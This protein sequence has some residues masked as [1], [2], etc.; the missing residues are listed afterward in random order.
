MTKNMT[1]LTAALAVGVGIHLALTL[2]LLLRYLEGRERQIGWW[3]VAYAFFATHVVAETL[4]T[5]FPEPSLIAFRHALFLAASWAMVQSFRQDPRVTIAALAGMLASVVLASQSWLAAAVIASVLGGGGFMASALLLYRQ[6]HGVHPVSIK[7]LFWGL[8]LTGLQALAYP[9]LRPHPVYAGVGAAFSGAF[10]LIFSVGIV[11][12][13]LQRSRDLATMSSIAE[14]LN[15][16]LDVPSALGRALDQ[17]VELMRLSSGWVFLRQNGDFTVAATKNLPLELAASGMA[18]MQG[19]CRCLQML[20]DGQLSEAVNVVDC[21]RLEQAGWDHPR[22]VT[23]PLRSAGGVI[24]V[25]NLVLPRRRALSIRELATLS[26]IGDQIG[27][28]AERARLYDEVRAKEVLRGELLQKLISA[29]E[30]ERRR[31]ARELHDEA[32]QAL[33]AL[34][35]NLEVAER[36]AAPDEQPRLGRLRE[37][38]E[39]TLGELRKMIYDLRPTILDDLGLAAAIRW[40]VKEAV[41]PQGLQVDLSITGLE[42]RLPPH[43]ET[44]VFRI[45]QEA[46]TNVLKHAGATHARVEVTVS[47]GQ[48]TLAVQD[49]GRGFDLA[50]VPRSREGRGMGLMG[51]QER[52]ELLGGAW[53]VTSRPNG[54]TRV[55]VVIPVEAAQR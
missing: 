14:T 1:I 3:T 19:D 12:L 30:D 26:A 17:L 52:A 29:H 9:V 45:L 39:D 35:L 46:C 28:A 38:A 8:L 23:V 34:I 27:L 32:G 43:M 44:A 20:R 49:D 54:G 2:F 51:M 13:A 4:L 55:E 33:T 50:A 6:E 18:R 42:R 53:K 11:L 5:I 7:L 21:Q 22:H 16:S 31:I 47:G 41:E 25:M 48:V 40:Y 10:T 24:G 37:I 15:R 36:S